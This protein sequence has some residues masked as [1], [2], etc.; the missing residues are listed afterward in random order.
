MPWH[1]YSRFS[2]EQ[3]I[4]RVRSPYL[5][6]ELVKLAFR[7]PPEATVAEP[8]LRLI[9]AGH[10]ELASIPTDRGLTWPARGWANRLTRRYHE[11]WAKA[12]YAYDYGMPQWL[13]RTDRLLRG[14]S[15]ERLFLG[16]Q[17]F[18]HFRSWYRDEL[19]S[20]VGD[21]LLSQ[22]AGDRWYVRKSELRRA[23][24]AHLK[25]TANFT[26]A[27]HKLLSLEL[28]HRTHLNTRLA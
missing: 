9:A 18:C 26:T 4:L 16:R 11:F 28:L 13:A 14:I 3:S 1:H 2:V 5:D 23:V 10:R 6:N 20:F 25:G 22:A 19:R 24:E 7:A 17:K 27:L 12:E 8:S 21:I 15:P